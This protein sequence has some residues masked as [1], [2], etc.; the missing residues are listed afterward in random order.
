MAALDF[1][2][3]DDCSLDS[4]FDLRKEAM[5]R[6]IK[7]PWIEKATT[8]PIMPRVECVLP[9]PVKKVRNE[10]TRVEKAVNKKMMLLQTRTTMRKVMKIVQEVTT[11]IKTYI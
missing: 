3:F 10:R 2:D 5:K 1:F 9:I 4:R 7:K 8:S 11:T 6:K